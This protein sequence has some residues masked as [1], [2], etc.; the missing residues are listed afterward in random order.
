LLHKPILRAA[1]RMDQHVRCPVTGRPSS[2]F[3][4]M[5]LKDVS[6]V[7][8]YRVFNIQ[9]HC[10]TYYSPRERCHSNDSSCYRNCLCQLP[11][12]KS[13]MKTSDFLPLDAVSSRVCWHHPSTELTRREER[14]VSR[15]H[16]D[17]D[18]CRRLVLCDRLFWVR[19]SLSAL[20]YRLIT[21]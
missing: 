4:Y 10:D 7:F 15:C 17:L 13:D 18:I 12:A 5:R 21:V 9:A 6:S 20:V 14:R 2:P 1:N 3:T 19:H 8:H 11:Q 16:S